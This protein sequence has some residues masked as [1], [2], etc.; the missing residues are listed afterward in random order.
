M[1]RNVVQNI[2]MC[3]VDF[4]L[5]ILG[6]NLKHFDQMRV[7]FQ[8]KMLWSPRRIND[9]EQ[10]LCSEH[11]WCFLPTVYT[12]NSAHCLTVVHQVKSHGS[13]CKLWQPGSCHR[14]SLVFTLCW[15]FENNFLVINWFL[16]VN[17]KLNAPSVLV[18]MSLDCL[19]CSCRAFLPASGFDLWPPQLLWKGFPHKKHFTKLLWAVM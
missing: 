10:W 18:S 1:E 3:D 16:W 6:F 17:K 11:L 8:E 5:R 14:L 19:H 12:K 9:R 4:K 2:L 13:Y 15:L 7:Y